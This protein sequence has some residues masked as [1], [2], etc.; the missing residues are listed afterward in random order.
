MHK[1]S[2]GRRKEEDRHSSEGALSILWPLLEACF[3]HG[4]RASHRSTILL[5]FWCKGGFWKEGWV[6]VRVEAEMIE[7]EQLLWEDLWLSTQRTLKSGS[8]H[9]SSKNRDG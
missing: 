4:L 6:R 1:S 3:L 7:E 9:G 2:L 8:V 5:I